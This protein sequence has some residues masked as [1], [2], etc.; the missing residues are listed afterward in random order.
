[1]IQERIADVQRAYDSPSPADA[2]AV[3]R[4]YDVRWV[5]AGGLERAYYPAAGLDKLRAMPELRLAYDRD[6]VQIFEVLP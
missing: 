1:M 5:F 3:I 4:K 6:G 2:L